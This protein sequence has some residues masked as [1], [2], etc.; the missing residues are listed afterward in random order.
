[1]KRNK[2]KKCSWQDSNPR[3]A[4]WR[5]K[6][7]PLGHRPEIWECLQFWAVITGHIWCIIIAVHIHVRAWAVMHGYNQI[8]ICWLMHL[9][10]FCFFPSRLSAVVPGIL[11]PLTVY[12]LC[13]SWTGHHHCQNYDVASW[14]RV[15][16]WDSSGHRPWSVVL[17]ILSP[18]TVYD[19]S[20]DWACHHHTQKHD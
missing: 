7:Y 14:V 2:S 1:M 18:L 11:S 3:P 17:C 8:T 4:S 5:G 9:F 13:I 15:P 10:S 6:I 20:V 16:F 12:G 19:F